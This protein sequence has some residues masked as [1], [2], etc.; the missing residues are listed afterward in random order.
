MK[1]N[2]YNKVTD[3]NVHYLKLTLPFY[4]KNVTEKEFM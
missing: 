1:F 4:H 3:P 2:F